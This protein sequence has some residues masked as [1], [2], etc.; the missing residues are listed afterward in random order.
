LRLNPN[1]PARF[2][3]LIASVFILAVYNAQV[4]TSY[5]L[6]LNKRAWKIR[7]ANLDSAILLSKKAFNILNSD[8]DKNTPVIWRGRAMSK[9]LYY[10]G[11]FYNQKGADSTAL[12]Y[13][14]QALKISQSVGDERGVSLAIGGMGLLYS[15]HGDFPKALDHYFRALKID[16]KISNKE[17]ILTRLGNIGVIYD[18]QKNYKKA[19]EYYDKALKIA[20]ELDKKSS[21]AIQYCNIGVVYYEQKQFDKA[22]EYFSKALEIDE[23][24]GNINGISRNLNNLATVYRDRKDYVKAL[25]YFKQAQKFAEEQ[26]NMDNIATMTGNVGIMY[27][28]LGN[29]PLSEKYLLKGLK[30]ANDISSIP[31]INELEEGITK[32][33]EAW[34]KPKQALEHYKIFVATKDSL[35]NAENIE[36]NV[37][38]EMNYEFDKKAAVNAAVHRKELLLLEAENKR[39]KQLRL[40]LFVIIALILA[41]LFFVKRAY[42]NKN[43]MAVFLSNESN[44]KEILLQEVHH[45]INNNLQIISSLL[46]LQANNADDTKLQEYLIQSQ[47]RIQSLAALHELLYQ[48]DRALDINIREYLEKVLDF[49]RDVINGKNLNSEIILKAP[50]LQIPTQ[51]AVPLALIVNE[52][53]TNSIKY[54]FEPGKQGKIEVLL[55]KHNEKLN[56]FVLQVSDNGKGLPPASGVRKDS[57]GLRLVNMMVK[58]IK[59]TLTQTSTPGA[60]FTC[61]F[62]LTK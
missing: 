23:K 6:E 1:I 14:N 41:V 5:V 26:G 44:R 27:T 53:V 17:G 30:I 32:L 12:D 52:L 58:Q 24:E 3:F 42:D 46:T 33:Y 55:Q 9:T 40:L 50:D 11:A 36:K 10:L 59:A 62:S 39:Q 37:R 16:E 15:N 60:T 20:I 18:T 29:Y 31:A 38:L 4:D 45:R 21:I 54:A 13:F 48:H 35:F 7:H 8:K 43:R 34:G 2:I 22:A 49:H 61:E 28:L 19:L 57:L 56:T 47:Q 51:K 25:D